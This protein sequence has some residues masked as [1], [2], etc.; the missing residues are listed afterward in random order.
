MAGFTARF[1]GL[2]GQLDANKLLWGLFY[3]FCVWFIIRQIRYYWYYRSLFKVPIGR[4]GVLMSPVPPHE[5]PKVLH[6]RIGEIGGIMATWNAGIPVIMISQGKY[7][8]PILRSNTNIRKNFLVGFFEEWLGK[9]LLTSSGEHWRSHRRAL[10]NT[11]HFNVLR[12]YLE[13]MKRNV[14]VFLDLMDKKAE[15]GETFDIFDYHLLLGL[16]VIFETAMGRNIDAQLAEGKNEYCQAVVTAARTLSARGQRPWLWIPFIWKSTALYQEYRSALAV[17]DKWKFETIRE[18]RTILAK[19]MLA[20]GKDSVDIDAMALRRGRLSFL[21]L[22]LTLKDANGDPA[23]DEEEIGEEVA[24]F[25]FAGHDTTSAALTWLTAEVAHNPQIQERLQQEVDEYWAAHDAL[26]MDDLNTLPYVN[27]VVKETLRKYPS[28]PT[29]GRVLDED[30]QCGEYFLPKDTI[31]FLHIDGI[32]NNPE[33]WNEPEVFNP[34]RFLNGNDNFDPYNYVPFSAGARNCIGQKFALQLIKTYVF[35]FFRRF[36]V[37][38]MID[39]V[40][41]KNY[42]VV[43]KPYEGNP[44]RVER[45]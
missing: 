33:D 44:V 10:T 41:L 26:D 34:E 25:M 14:S 29:V 42:V 40:P 6:Q 15:T 18:R 7:A 21:D 39:H 1:L 19:A 5:M 11:F 43:D 17:L 27:A 20:S 22:M 9:G 24:N 35:Y 16:D 2:D 12:H 8:A 38:P 30:A 36:R 45:R 31:I 13:S 23:F 37:V 3:I 4:Y 28:A 32:N